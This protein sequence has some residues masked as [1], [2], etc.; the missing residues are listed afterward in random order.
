MESW[1]LQVPQAQRNVSAAHTLAK[2]AL[3]MM[4]AFVCVCAAGPELPISRPARIT[5]CR[6]LS[7][8]HSLSQD[9][10]LTSMPN[11]ARKNGTW[12]GPLLIKKMRDNRVLQWSCPYGSAAYVFASHRAA[13]LVLTR[14]HNHICQSGIQQN[15]RISGVNTQTDHVISRSRRASWVISQASATVNWAL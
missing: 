14:L 7:A 13:K 8:L 5:V 11:S 4:Q 6:E 3:C 2:H 12:Q 9:S 10:A 15:T 1:K